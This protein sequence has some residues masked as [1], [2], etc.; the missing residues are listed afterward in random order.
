MPFLVGEGDHVHGQPGTG[1]RDARHHPQ[2]AVQPARFVLRLDMAAHQ[3]MRPVA[4]VPPIHVADAVDR[5]VQPAGLH[6][7]DQPVARL[8]VLGRVGRAVHTGAELADLAQFVEVAKERLGVD[9]FHTGSLTARRRGWKIG[10]ASYA[11]LVGRNVKEAD[12]GQIR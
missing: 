7:L 4:G 9:F 12:R 6:P 3:Q 2:R 8:H 5:G 10:M 11:M 1:Q